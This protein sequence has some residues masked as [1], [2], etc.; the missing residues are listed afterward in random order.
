MNRVA[1]PWGTQRECAVTQQGDYRRDIPPALVAASRQKTHITRDGSHL[2]K[3][4]VNDE[5]HRGHRL[6][7]RLDGR[8]LFVQLKKEQSDCSGRSAW[9]DRDMVC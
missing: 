8:L 2:A 3:D 9:D 1:C 6:Y 5:S 4:G 7:E